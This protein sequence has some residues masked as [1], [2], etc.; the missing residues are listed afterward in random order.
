MVHWSFQQRKKAGGIG[1]GLRCEI[2]YL[3]CCTHPALEARYCNMKTVKPYLLLIPIKSF[4]K[5]LYFDQNSK[6]KI[7][8]MK[9][10]STIDINNY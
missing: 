10:D 1:G 7:I 9:T 3:S 5:I 2:S 4:L 6:Y 8:A